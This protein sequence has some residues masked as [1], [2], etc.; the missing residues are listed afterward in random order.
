MLSL[1]C[2]GAAKPSHNDHPLW[3]PLLV[4]AAMI[5]K[6]LEL[7]TCLEL[8]LAFGVC[9]LPTARPACEFP[10]KPEEFLSCVRNADAGK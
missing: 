10:T 5:W 1:G 8:G 9:L 6:P 2:Q 3:T 4:S 7:Q